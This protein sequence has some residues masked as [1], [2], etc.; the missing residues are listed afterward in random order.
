MGVHRSFFH[1]VDS[2]RLRLGLVGIGSQKEKKMPG[3]NKD[4]P[5]GKESAPPFRKWPFAALEKWWLWAIG[6]LMAILLLFK[7]QPAETKS[8]P[9]KPDHNRQANQKPAGKGS[10]LD[11]FEN[12]EA[13]KLS[14]GGELASKTEPRLPKKYGKLIL[15]SQEYIDDP[16]D[17]D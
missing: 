9:L 3:A 15:I 8:T 10:W 2:V 7:G 6:L 14:V 1:S 13:S 11:A 16:N 12:E 17:D 5:S 4:I